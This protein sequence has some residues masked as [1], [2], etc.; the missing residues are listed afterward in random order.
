MQ[1]Y[2]E[3]MSVSE[4]GKGIPEKKS[5]SFN[6]GERSSVPVLWSLIGDIFS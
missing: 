2:L 5:G 6:L 4:F 1:T 3:D